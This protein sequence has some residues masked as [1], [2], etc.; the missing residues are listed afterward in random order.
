LK[1]FLKSA[2]ITP[3]LPE[4]QTI[5]SP[6]PA[7]PHLLQVV[8]DRRGNIWDGAYRKLRSE[9]PDLIADYGGILVKHAEIKSDLPLAQKMSAVIVKELCTMTNRQWRFRIPWRHE[10][11]VVRDLVDKVGRVLTKFQTAGSVASNADPIHAGLPFAGIC[12]LIP[13]LYPRFES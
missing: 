1:A 2:S 4:S 11:V 13:V 3:T 12:V 10:P 7:T 6:D 8:G 5:P 9:R